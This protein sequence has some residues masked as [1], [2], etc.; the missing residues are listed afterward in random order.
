MNTLTQNVPQ[1]QQQ[2]PQKQKKTRKKREPKA[3]KG[4]GTGNS[5]V[6]AN[7]VAAK[8][9]KPSSVIGVTRSISACLRCRTRKTRCDQKFP[10][11][12]SCL[13]AEVECVGIDAATGREIPRSY[14]S[15]LEDRIAQLEMQLKKDGKGGLDSGTEYTEDTGL[16]SILERAAASEPTAN[17]QAGSAFKQEQDV[18]GNTPSTSRP[19]TTGKKKGSGAVD[20]LMSQVKSVSVDAASVPPSSFLGSSSGLS[21]ARLLFTAV[22]FK[23]NSAVSDPLPAP[24]HIEPASL[25][26]KAE[27]EQLLSV[28]F[29]LANPQMPVLHREQ[30]LVRYFQPVY[31]ILSP[32]VS[33]ASDY[34]TIGVPV[35]T[36]A[37]SD[38]VVPQATKSPALYFL[39]IVFGI[40]TAAMHQKNPTH[41][42]EAY[43]SAAMKH[44]DSVF[45]SPNR[46]EALQGILLLALYS[47]MRPAVPGVWYVLGSATRLCVDL[48]LHTEAGIKSWY[49][50]N[51][52][53]VTLPGHMNIPE[54]DAATLD[55]RRR[56]FW[57]TYALDRQ[58][59][60]YLGRPFGI[61]E[62]SVKVPFPSELDDALIVDSSFGDPNLDIVD[63]SLEK[64]TSSSYKTI[65]LA[66]FKI[67]KLQ[68]EIQSI[69]YECASLPRQYS[70]LDEWRE[71]Q[72]ER[73]EQWHHECPKS[74]KKM[75]CTFN[76][77][78]IELNYHQTRV[79]LYGLAPA[80]T[81]PPTPL[82]YRVIAE[83]GAKV[84]QNYADLNN[85][86]NINYTWVVVHNLFTAGTSYL[87]ALYHSPE[88]RA[89]TSVEEISKH[90][91]ACSR[92]LTSMID[93]CAA[94]TSCRDTFELLTAA[95][96]KLYYHE[97]AGIVMQLPD[98]RHVNKEV[99]ISNLPSLKGLKAGE[100]MHP[101]VGNL[102]TML[103]EEETDTSAS[104]P[105]T[106]RPTTAAPSEVSSSLAPPPFVDEEGRNSWGDLDLF[107]QEAA[108][109]DGVSPNGTSD[110]VTGNGHAP[111]GNEMLFDDFLPSVNYD[112]LSQQQQQ[113]V[114]QQ[115]HDDFGRPKNDG[116]RIYDIINEVP[117]AAIWDQFFAPIGTSGTGG[118]VGGSGSGGGNDGGWGNGSEGLYGNVY[119][120]K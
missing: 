65:A 28:Y 76:L 1:Q 85:Q 23:P 103:P 105:T 74:T 71:T 55:M 25:P 81:V 43:H 53:G 21:F 75:N 36:S 83:S 115:Q 82:C 101:H 95:I 78:F 119:D 120:F 90:A 37:S 26:P 73:L 30:F 111:G 47:V 88:V 29:S 45:A 116:Q 70:T 57:C 11:C 4:S 54:Y 46:L 118:G 19:L 27:A 87:Y 96:L 102:M 68:A 69:L 8:V 14:V 79:L 61:P 80:Y 42:S 104:T 63:Y 91:K 117:M 60:V 86:T 106:T 98:G 59:C 52:S 89:S 33:L 84:I 56:L 18:S 51:R 5:A 110:G 49:K 35:G 112:M 64:S 48:G 15:H 72:A 41:T 62:H 107:F 13:K 22:K 7:T 16:G 2:P 50:N 93:Q 38:P 97:Q 109:M 3:G 24:K 92:V 31:D 39:N 67:R 12:T 58:V 99:L 77:R 113:Q 100:G 34:T 6:G 40:A 66:F 94:A 20:S 108:Q 9:T 114:N 32:G 17:G 10:S 44:V